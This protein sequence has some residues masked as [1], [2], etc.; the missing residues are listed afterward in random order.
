MHD[1]LVSVKVDAQPISHVKA[2]RSGQELTF[3][4]HDNYI[5][6]ELPVLKGYEVISIS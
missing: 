4:Q 5:D 6:I 1:L 3:K 2:L